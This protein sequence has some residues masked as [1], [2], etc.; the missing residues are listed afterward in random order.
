LLQTI[1]LLLCCSPAASL[2]ISRFTRRHL[3]EASAVVVSSGLSPQTSNAACLAGDL[4]PNCIGVYKVPM[5]NEILPFLNTKERLAKYA[6]EL[7]FVPPP[8]VPAS[9]KL[10]RASLET[11]RQ[12]ADDIQG[13]VASGKLEQAGICVLKFIPQLTV[14]GRVLVEDRAAL[15]NASNVTMDFQR[16]QFQE[17]FQLA[18]NSW[19]SVDISIGQGLRGQ[20]GVSAVAQLQLLAEIK[21]AKQ[22]LDDFLDYVK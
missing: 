20:M 15:V 14:A 19:S 8:A 10:A 16:Q 3:F 18:V 12:A 22:A 1:C 7:N 11:L 9:L 13:L 5:D 4:N 21:E 6:P 17:K 2:F